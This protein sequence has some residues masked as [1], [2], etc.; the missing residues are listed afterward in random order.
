VNAVARMVE[1]YGRLLEP[2]E[3]KAAARKDPSVLAPHAL[4]RHRREL[5]EP[6]PSEGFARIEDVP[7]VRRPPE[8]GGGRAVVVRL[9]GAAPEAIRRLADRRADGSFVLGVAWGPPADDDVVDAVR[10]AHAQDGPPVCWCRRP[11]P[12]LGAVL[13][14]RHRLDLAR[15]TYVGRDAADR[16]WARV[17]GLAYEDAG[18]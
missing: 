1:R 10:C 14:A 11:L 17:L 16:A 15:C 9:D 7:F 18:G 12:G 5:E 6:D 13:A 3:M 2:D 4:F 8:G